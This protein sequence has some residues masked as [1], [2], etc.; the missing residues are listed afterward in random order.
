[1]NNRNEV[2]FRLN[3]HIRTSAKRRKEQ[4][5]PGNRKTLP[6]RTESPADEV[7][8]TRYASIVPAFL[9]RAQKRRKN[10]VKRDTSALEINKL[11]RRVAVAASDK[12]ESPEIVR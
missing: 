4:I 12:S 7:P 2:T 8:R 1:M 5:D 11:R 6:P 3:L 10:I 9:E